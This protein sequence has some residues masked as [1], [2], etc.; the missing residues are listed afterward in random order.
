MDK[1]FQCLNRKKKQKLQLMINYQLLI[2]IPPF[3]RSEQESIIIKP[4]PPKPSVASAID[5]LLGLFDNS[6][7]NTSHQAPVIAPTPSNTKPSLIKSEQ[8]TKKTVQNSIPEEACPA[9]KSEP[10]QIRPN[11]GYLNKHK[12][13]L[14]F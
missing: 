5:D 3:H 12:K 14:F 6:A 9:A 4:T 13:I 8:Q 11:I 2:Q 7:A 1:N 10:S